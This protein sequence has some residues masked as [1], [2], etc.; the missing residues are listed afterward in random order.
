VACYRVKFTFTFY[1]LRS[2]PGEHVR[3]KALKLNL[4]F[5]TVYKK[6]NTRVGYTVLPLDTTTL[7]GRGAR[8]SLVVKALR[9]KPAGRGFDS[10]WCHWN[11]SVT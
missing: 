5:N 10:R 4:K 9:Y 2:L 6:V 1:L 8:G 7:T 11:F 3:Y